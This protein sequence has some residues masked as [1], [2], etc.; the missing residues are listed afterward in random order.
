MPDPANA[1]DANGATIQDSFPA[2]LWRRAT[3]IIE[4]LA[5]RDREHDRPVW[6]EGAMR[7]RTIALLLASVPAT[8]KRE[9]G[10]KAI[11]AAALRDVHDQEPSW[12]PAML[13]AAIAAD[14]ATI[15]A[16]ASG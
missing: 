4:E 3:E 7:L 8:S 16:A 6:H 1:I 10:R 11:L 5:R 15:E 13:E 12:A 14:M 9:V 2:T